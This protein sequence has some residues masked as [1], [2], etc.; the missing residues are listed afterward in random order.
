M[1]L[2]FSRGWTVIIN[3]TLI[4]RISFLLNSFVG[5]LVGLITGL[6]SM[7]FAKSSSS[8]VFD[9]DDDSDVQTLLV[10]FSFLF[11][12]LQVHHW[13][14]ANMP[15]YLNSMHFNASQREGEGTN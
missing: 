14:V 5:C 6:V 7:V 4:R 11:G 12:F 3:D 9:D 1:D 15:I 10:D 13:F 2:F 8:E